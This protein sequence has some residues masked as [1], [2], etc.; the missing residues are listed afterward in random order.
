MVG[1]GLTFAETARRLGVSASGVTETDQAPGFVAPPSTGTQTISIFQTLELALRLNTDRLP[2][3]L[4]PTRCVPAL[5]TICTAP[6]PAPAVPDCMLYWK[7]T[8]M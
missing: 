6:P 2:Q 8:G 5:L 3:Y 1:D 7:L 4:S